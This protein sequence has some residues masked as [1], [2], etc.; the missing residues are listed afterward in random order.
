VAVASSV[1]GSSAL[2]AKAVLMCVGRV[3][4]KMALKRTSPLVGIGD[5]IWE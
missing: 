2:S 1:E 3:R 4:R 5:R